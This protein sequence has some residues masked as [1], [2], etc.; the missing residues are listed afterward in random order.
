MEVSR[1]ASVALLASGCF[2]PSY[3]DGLVCGAGPQPCP[4]GQ[5]CGGD[6][7]CHAQPVGDD[8]ADQDAPVDAMPLG[9]FAMPVA[10]AELADPGNDQ[11]PALDAAMLVIIWSS[12]RAGGAGGGDLWMAERTGPG[13]KFG[14]LHPIAEVSSASFELHPSLTTDGSELYFET[15]RGGNSDIWRALRASATSWQTP[16]PVAELNSNT[17]DTGAAVSPSGLEL[18]LASNRDGNQDLY[19]ST[20]AS[21]AAA[22]STPIRI[23]A[24]ATADIESGPTLT[25]DEIYFMRQTTDSKQQ[26]YR[27][28]RVDEGF[29]PATPVTELGAGADPWVSADGRVLYMNK[30]L[31][32]YV[33]TR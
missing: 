22:W 27:A 14:D 4:P 29:G 17:T 7:R 21:P 20:R 16:T 13:Q 24:L 11:D 23:A 33:S 26:I 6:G 28:A 31:E 10:V 19:L 12:D 9:P 25:D 30:G 5:T 15:T 32:I 8:A 1:L 3:P 2:S 18:V